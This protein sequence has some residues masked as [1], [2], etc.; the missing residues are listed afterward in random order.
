MKK[1]L[2]KIFLLLV[3]IALLIAIFPKREEGNVVKQCLIDYNW[4]EFKDYSYY[5]KGRMSGSPR[6]IVI[7]HSISPGM[8]RLKK[9]FENNRVSCHYFIDSNGRLTNVISDTCVAYHA[10]FSYWNGI[11]KLNDSSIC[12]EILNNSPFVHDINGKQYK[13]L[14]KLIK[15]LKNKYNIKDDN[16]VSHSDVAYFNNDF[17][18]DYLN[19][20][21]D[22]SYLFKWKKLAKSGIGIWYNERKINKNDYTIL[23]Y[24]GD[25]K[26]ELIDIKNKLKKIGYRIDD[27][28]NRYDISFYMQSIVFH[29]RFFPEQLIMAGQGLWTKSSTNVLNAV[30]SAFE[31][32][33]NKSE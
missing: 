23:Y 24:F 13:T 20:K 19:R 2:G 12:I 18:D 1:I 29:R 17:I 27:T 3:F 5:T 4:Y 14:I 8:N 11:E 30:T 21:Q 32:Y 31:N 26:D 22:V 9:V 7:H 15:K 6:Q 33:R 10:G 28:N 25:E 16:I